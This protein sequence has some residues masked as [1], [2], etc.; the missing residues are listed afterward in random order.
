M[1]QNPNGDKGILRVKRGDDPLFETRL[2][3]F[4]NFDYHN[5]TPM[6]FGPGQ[7]LVLEVECKGVDPE[8]SKQCTSAGYFS[9]LLENLPKK[10]EKEASKS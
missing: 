8:L 2:E 3:N 1:L 7:R 4:R 9:G 5:V 6:V 10:E